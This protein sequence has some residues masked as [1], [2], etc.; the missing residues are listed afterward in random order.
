VAA[1]EC[2]PPE[3]WVVQLQALQDR[4][5]FVAQHVAL[6]DGRAVRLRE[7]VLL[8]LGALPFQFR[9]ERADLPHP[10]ACLRLRLIQIPRYQ[11]RATVSVPASKSISRHCSPHTSEIRSPATSAVSIMSRVWSL[12]AARICWICSAVNSRFS[13]TSFLR[14]SLTPAGGLSPLHSFQSLAA[15]NIDDS[16]PRRPSRDHQDSLSLD[17]SHAS[18]MGLS[19]S[20]SFIAPNAG[21]TWLSIWLVYRAAVPAPNSGSRA[22]VEDKSAVDIVLRLLH[23][24]KNTMVG[25]GAHG[26]KRCEFWA[27]DL[28]S[29]Q[30]SQRAEVPCRT[31]F[32]FGMSG[33][34][35]KLYIYGAGF[36]IEV[37]DT[38]TLTHERTWDL[39]NDVTGAGMIVLP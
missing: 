3:T 24:F 18:T 2:V 36:E 34:G 28:M 22:G 33:D 1:P 15:A 13:R 16:T 7:N 20:Q 32:S 12:T 4:P 31:R 35:K 10:L 37:Y 23:A 39:N 30:I 9:R 11:R 29:D 5:Q 17:A 25:T 14:P 21:S 19:M 27:F 26:N 6:I 8:R 38:V